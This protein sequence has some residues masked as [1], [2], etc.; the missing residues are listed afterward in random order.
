MG[1]TRLEWTS[2]HAHLAGLVEMSVE[3]SEYASMAR[4]RKALVLVCEYRISCT[5]YL[6]REAAEGADVECFTIQSTRRS[7]RYTARSLLAGY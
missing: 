6:K 1:L 3:S 7:D 4:C 2:C 5:Y